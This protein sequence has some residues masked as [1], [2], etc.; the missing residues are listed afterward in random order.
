MLSI[1]HHCMFRII[2]TWQI[3]RWTFNLIFWQCSP[4]IGNT[5]RKDFFFLQKEIF[6]NRNEK[7]LLKN[8]FQSPQKTHAGLFKTSTYTAGNFAWNVEWYTKATTLLQVQR[9]LQHSVCHQDGHRIAN[10][11]RQ[12]SAGLGKRDQICKSV[13]NPSPSEDPEMQQ[14]CGQFRATKSIQ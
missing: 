9:C 1:Q 10:C 4:W 3:A 12:T 7:P 2:S 14:G 13:N 6:L 8:E 11:P 5:G